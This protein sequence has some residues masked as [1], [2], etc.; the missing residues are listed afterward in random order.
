M[1]HVAMAMFEYA[2]LLTIKFGKQGKI[3]DEKDQSEEKNILKRCRKIDFYA[4][5]AF[6]A[7]YL[8]TVGTYF[9]L[10]INIEL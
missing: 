2:T 4:L 10:Y 3:S 7:T 1:I 8:L 6:I 5:R 9:Y